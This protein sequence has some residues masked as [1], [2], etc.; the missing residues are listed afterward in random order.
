MGESKGPKV[1]VP[2]ELAAE[3]QESTEEAAAPEGELQ[4]G[5][6]QAA[7]PGAGLQEG[8]EE[9]A[10]PEGESSEA[11]DEAEPE[12]DLATQLEEAQDRHLRLAAEFE[13]FKRRALRERQD[14]LNYANENL[15]KELL[16]MVD[17]LER[18]LEHARNQEGD[19]AEKLLE[20][21]ELTY[22]SLIQTLES[23]GVSVVEAEGKPFDPQYHEAIRQVPS[24][25]H[26]PGTVIEVFQRG[27]LLRDRL[28]RPAQVPSATLPSSERQRLGADW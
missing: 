4:E 20:G 22:R 26:H 12:A 23:Y 5:A 21:V 9:P 10:A 28:L 13:N 25:E 1:A 6:E 18:A 16:P 27:Y 3:L 24:D 11:G 2:E 7:A 8:D 19:G 15:V 14:L 17:N